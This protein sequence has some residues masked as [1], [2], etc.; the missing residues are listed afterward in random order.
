MLGFFLAWIIF[1]PRPVPLIALSVTEYPAALPPHALAEEDLRRF[2][3]VFRGYRNVRWSPLHE[4]R[5]GDWKRLLDSQLNTAVTGGPGG[6]RF[7]P[8]NNVAVVY[9]SAHGVVDS[10]G[11]PCLLMTFSEPWDDSTWVPV[12]EVLEHIA[13]HPRWKNSD[14]KTLV[15]LDTGEL[16]EDWSIG[17]FQNGFAELLPEL[18]TSLDIPTLAVIHSTRGSQQSWSAPELGGTVFAYYVAAGLRGAADADDDGTVRLHELATY[19]ENHVDAWVHA[20]RTARQQP[21]LLPENAPDFGV[22]YVS[23]Y[24]QPPVEP[25]SPPPARNEALNQLWSRYVEM[26]STGRR[27]HAALA[28]GEVQG[29][30][31][32]LEE[33]LLAGSAYDRQFDTTAA[34]VDR[35]L[36]QISRFQTIPE[37]PTGSLSLANLNGKDEEAI[38]QA[39]SEFQ[40][41][42]AARTDPMRTEPVPPPI[43]TYADAA[44]ALWP[45]ILN[46]PAGEIEVQ[47]NDVL[48]FL[49][50]CPQTPRADLKEVHFLRL[51]EHLDWPVASSAVPSVAGL[52]GQIEQLASPRD[53]RTQFW[54]HGP[55]GDAEETARYV[56]DD[57]LVGN[58]VALDSLQNRLAA[59]TDGTAEGSLGAV[60]EI[61]ETTHEAYAIRDEVW[62]KLPALAI[63]LMTYPDLSRDRA[64]I[65]QQV[66]SLIGSQ[67]QLTEMLEKPPVLSTDSLAVT[68]D[69]E[70]IADRAEADLSALLAYYDDACNQLAA[71]RAGGVRETARKIGQT[72][73][74]PI[75]NPQRETLRRKW[76]A[77]F[78]QPID[79]VDRGASSPTTSETSDD[80][81]LSQLTEQLAEHPSLALLDLHLGPAARKALP[82]IPSLPRLDTRDVSPEA[83]R[84]MRLLRLAKLG[85]DLRARFRAISPWV[86]EYLR[87]E[88][89]SNNASTRTSTS[90][91]QRLAEIDQ[92]VRAMQGMIGA[93]P[94]FEEDASQRLSRLDA[95]LLL[96]WHAK[97]S[98]SDFWGP[99]AIGEDPFFL[100]AVKQ[101]A[102]AARRVYPSASQGGQQLETDAKRLAQ[103]AAQWQPISVENITV[104]PEQ[105]LARQHV[106]WQP[107]SAIPAGTSA[108]FVARPDG[109]L[110]PARAISDQRE[111][112]RHGLPTRAASTE[113]WDF[114]LPIDSA[115]RG[116]GLLEAKAVFRG[117]QRTVLFSVG[118][119]I[120]DALV[121]FHKPEMPSPRIQVRGDTTQKMQIMFIL[122]CSSS[123]SEQV[124]YE[125]R[126]Q[127]RLQVAQ[128]RLEEFL[129]SLRDEDYEVGLM[130]YGH[131]AGWPSATAKQPR[132]VNPVYEG[133]HPGADVEVVIPIQPLSDRLREDV[134]LVL[135]RNSRPF[136]ETPLY[137]SLTTAL[138]A[139]SSRRDASRRVIVI[140]DGVDEQSADAPVGVRKNR[141]H[142]QE[143]IARVPA[144]IDIIGFG[145]KEKFRDDRERTIWAS[146]QE[147]LKAISKDSGGEFY[148]ARD[149]SELLA[150]L[151]ESLRMVKFFVQEPGLPPPPERDALDLNQTWV[152]NRFREPE[153]LEVRVMGHDSRVPA[154]PV[155]LEGG[156]ALELLFNR[157]SGRLEHLRYDFELQTE[158][159]NLRVPQD[160]SR[161][162]F[163]GAHLPRRT[164]AREMEFWVS[165]QN[166]AAERFSPR[167]RHVWAEIRPLPAR[168]PVFYLQ[169][170]EFVPGL[171]VPMLRFRVSPWPQEVLQAELRLWV[172]W[173]E[174]GGGREIPLKLA[175]NS[176]VDIPGTSLQIEPRAGREGEAYQVTVTEQ[177][178]GSNTREL[179]RVQLRPPPDHVTRSYFSSSGKARHIFAYEDRE[180]WKSETPRLIVTS[181]EPDGVRAGWL[182]TGP[183][184]VDLPRR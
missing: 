131:R 40:E 124:V 3:N 53:P 86:N 39:R 2:E 109:G 26:E 77:N 179:L 31:S 93:R 65:F 145:M 6:G 173:D 23:G 113:R 41:W 22:A 149:P 25:L 180:F 121:A 1:R 59:L 106:E 162:F 46:S 94:P 29:G 60:R 13:R 181:M 139:F 88:I 85:G 147:A 73:R 182:A 42:R 112:R 68:R 119:D 54:L 166:D 9:L 167:P 129:E 89:G 110:W 63:W 156:E 175:E 160:R 83:A 159:S 130:L 37:V 104:L 164:A 133:L 127:N 169:D 71:D 5:E 90:E 138:D 96:L 61:S 51:L 17:L 44:A 35:L 117:H 140:T 132:W 122:D 165:V 66:A 30:L 107:D 52:R 135:T 58:A 95:H 70:K 34:S 16:R 91:R 27:R 74:V 111:I 57:L 49:A 28:M 69:L 146:G 75:A 67:K 12:R 72:L 18:V 80:E 32:K 38:D 102:S 158:K 99:R 137:Y 114:L 21:L 8:E 154:A 101:H 184:Q 82:A 56:L 142:V 163:V 155:M 97:R 98:L 45:R 20:Y 47:R 19:L 171:P 153:S 62:A 50:L 134:H 87:G 10:E 128:A 76:L 43:S 144:Q 125:G 103:I 36:T 115:L 108:L 100:E 116:N 148:T 143:A 161:A 172:S 79:V 118:T 123:M 170:V 78:S 157:S 92:I 183:M 81:W 141:T 177:H 48:E 55:M 178:L 15:V 4:G 64:E 7:F 136:G 152:A 11:R 174:D 168:T 84:R 24:E 105:T 150:R 151:R 120:P 126:R 14:V 176:Q 33:L